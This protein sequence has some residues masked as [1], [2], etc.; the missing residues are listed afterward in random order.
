MNEYDKLLA[1]VERLKNKGGYA[2]A[3]EFLAQMKLLFPEREQDI[4]IEI[5][6][7]KFDLQLYQDVLNDATVYVNSHN[8]KVNQWVLSHFYDPF[9]NEAREIY[10]E[11]QDLLLRY[12]YFYGQLSDGGV[13][14]LYYDNVR[15]L[16]Y[17]NS[18]KIIS[19]EGPFEIE[20]PSDKAIV[21]QNMLN[22]ENLV[23]QLEK[24]KYTGPIPGYKQPLYLYYTPEIFS[25]LMQSVRMD[26][27]L[28]DERVVFLIGEKNV[29]TFFQNKQSRF[30]VEVIGDNA[31]QI[32]VLLYRMMKEREQQMECDKAQMMEYYQCAQQDIDYRIRQR[33]PRILI[34]TSF[35]TTVLKYHARNLKYVA[36]QLG[37]EVELS[38][39]QDAIYGTTRA[40]FYAIMDNFKPDIIISLDTFRFQEGEMPKEV[41]FVSWVQDPLP[42]VMNT[43]TPLKL[44]HRDFVMNHFTTWKTF[45][46]L[47]YSDQCLIDAPIPANPSIYRPYQLASEEYR[48]YSCDICFVCHA[49]DVDAHLKGLVQS[50]HNA[51]EEEISLLYKSY[52]NYVYETGQPFYSIKLFKDYIIGAS[53]DCFGLHV[54]EDGLKLLAEDMYYWFN[55]RVY[56]QALVDWILD[57][58]FTNIKLWGNGWKDNPKYAPYAMGPAENG[59]TLSKIYQASKIVVGNNIMTTAAARAWETMLSGGFYLSNYIPEED[60]IT[61]IRKII[62]VG[63][64]VIMF[65][66]KEDLVN[67]L[68]YYLEHEEERQLMIE[69][70]RTAS[71]EKMTFESLLKRVLNEIAERI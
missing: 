44:K 58:G 48:K 68:H 24:S 10:R 69:K 9:L 32:D 61:D 36:E 54:T 63:E 50:L 43:E 2:E 37:L 11:N 33:S 13:K 59:E 19:F 57:A 7:T 5:L 46:E 39:E 12:K 51:W 16:Y 47:G 1:A 18:E 55:Q 17:C 28:I 23:E 26:R 42:V 45:Y 30:P 49:S 6:Q 14:A 27:L 67:K 22:I 38:L 4:T 56:R 8:D 15:S 66:D 34:L 35:F 65:Y 41:V 53:A 60:D 62:T 64:D 31:Q 70:G 20:I 25:A 21:I 52:Q 71:L 40:D 3:L 29:E